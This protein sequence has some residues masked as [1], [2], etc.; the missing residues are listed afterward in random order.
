MTIRNDTELM[1]VAEVAAYLR[2][3]PQTI[4]NRV[5]LKTIPHIRV[6]GRPMFHRPT[7]DAWWFEGDVVGSDAA[8][9][10]A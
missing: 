10:A 5:S 7:I 3:S 9:H 6:G 2:R 4:Y 1:T 8:Q